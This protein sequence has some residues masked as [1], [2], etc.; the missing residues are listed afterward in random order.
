ML[1]ACAGNLVIPDFTQFTSDLKTI[2]AEVSA[3][4]GGSVASYI[5]QVHHHH[6]H[7]RRRR[8]Q[9]TCCLICAS[10]DLLRCI[11]ALAERSESRAVC[12]CDPHDRWAS[13]GVWRCKRGVHSTVVLQTGGVRHCTT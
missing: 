10:I 2:I 5:P 6:H 9:R 13:M 7:H 12:R 1:L 8:R 3:V 11:G 4:D